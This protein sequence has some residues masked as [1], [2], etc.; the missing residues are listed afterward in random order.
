[1]EIY[2]LKAVGGEF[3]LSTKR[4]CNI[5]RNVLQEMNVNFYA[6]SCYAE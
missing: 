3:S 1:M 2:L 5:K 6:F 4:I